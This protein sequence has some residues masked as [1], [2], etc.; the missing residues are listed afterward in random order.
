M[1]LHPYCI[2]PS[3]HEPAAVTG[4]DG[5][6]VIAVVE[7]DLAAWASEHPEPV[8]ASVAAVR[9]HDAVI[10]VA[11]TE[12][13]TP[14]PL[15]FGQW[16]ADPDVL[17]ERLGEHAE[18]WHELLRVFAGAVE[19]GIRLTPA[20]AAVAAGQPRAASGREYMAQLAARVHD[21]D[22]VERDHARLLERIGESLGDVAF[23]TASGV[24]PEDGRTLWVAHLVRRGR[25]DEY[26][27]IADRTAQQETG[28]RTAVTGP[29]PPYSFGS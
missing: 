20:A 28:Y 17:R 16:A 26:R 8:A 1:G 5:A 27:R 4:L 22:A 23:R 14:V 7:A 13:V 12:Q 2:A 6:P 15:R 21:R 18:R 24:A 10:R 19:M 3:D 11:M 29:W 25:A 9:A